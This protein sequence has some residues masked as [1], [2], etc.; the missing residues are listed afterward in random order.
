MKVIIPVAGVGTRLKPHTLTQPKPLLQIGGKTI[1]DYLLEPITG[2]KPDE[3]VFVI[4]YKGDMIKDYVRRNYEFKATF[5]PQDK[6]LGLGYALHIALNAL[7][8]S[9]V[10]ILLGD[11]VVEGDLKK[12]VTAGD[13]TLGLHP[14]EDPQRF[15]IAEINRDTVV[16]LEEKPKEPKGNLALI[17]LYYFSESG[18]LKRELR[19]LVDS[20]KKTRG[21]IQLTDA[22]AG[23]L[24]RKIKF[25]P[26]EVDKWFDCGKKE[27][28][29]A[30]NRH[31]LEKM[32]EP[33]PIKGTSLEPPV[34]ISEE[35]RIENSVIGPNVSIAAGTRVRNCI[36][37][38]AI[39]GK[40][41]RLE[42]LILEKSIVGNDAAVKG[43]KKVL[44]IGDSTQISG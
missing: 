2:L 11:T 32:P 16:S 41:A 7:T 28:M 3:V 21:E 33:T 34:Y 36:I 10:L 4:G 12:F 25:T 14:V 18:L 19:Q 44:N 35:A 37:S 23:M 39:I 26:F 15:G 17:G 38:D 6:L 31:F 22:L 42:N 40:D 24:K 43:E 30:T 5:V 9:P 29:L 1:I 13:Y 8:E 27:T 20:G